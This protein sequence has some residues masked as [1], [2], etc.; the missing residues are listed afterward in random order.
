MTG[1]SPVRGSEPEEP[2][3]AQDRLVTE[4]RLLRART[5]LSLV[6]LAE[7]T[8]FSKS[9]WER[10]LSARTR[11]PRSAVE[12][13]CRIAGEPPDV[14]LALWDLAAPA[15]RTAGASKKRA[16]P[17]PPPLRA[18]QEGGR[19]RSQRTPPAA[20]RPPGPVHRR[21]VLPAALA[22]GAIAAIGALLHHLSGAA[23]DPVR[24]HR[25]ACDNRSPA[26]SLCAEHST[27]L[28]AHRLTTGQLVEIRY[29]PPCGTAW[30]RIG[31]THIGDQVRLAVP[32][33]PSR[34]ATVSDELDAQGYVYTPMNSVG[35]GQPIT[36]CLLPATRRDPS[37][38]TAA[39]Q[40][41]P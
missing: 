39:I 26:S 38:F 12:E 3:R 11:L 23:A 17:E 24:C 21:R 18:G 28:D 19:P 4:L 13:L 40:A 10:Y 34:T 22:V 14:M 29:S 5:G 1:T 15:W 6:A 33:A 37:C 9:S 41:S 31:N 8:P 32:G 27:T 35:D 20:G 36:A 25:A 30:A 2:S 16:T 7:K